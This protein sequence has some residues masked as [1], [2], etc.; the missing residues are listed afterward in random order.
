MVRA[1]ASKRGGG[2]GTFLP[3]TM[4]K[5]DRQVGRN[6]AGGMGD[7]VLDPLHV[8]HP[9]ARIEARL[10]PLDRTDVAAGDPAFDGITSWRRASCR[11]VPPGIRRPK[12][13]LAVRE[14]ATGPAHRRRSSTAPAPE[15]HVP[16]ANPVLAGQRRRHLDVEP[17][18]Q[19]D[20]QRTCAS[21]S[22]RPSRSIASR[23]RSRL[24]SSTSRRASLR[25][26]SPSPEPPA[27]HPNR[28]DNGRTGKFRAGGRTTWRLDV[29]E[30]HRE[31]LRGL[32]PY[33]MRS[34][35]STSTS[36]TLAVAVS[37]VMRRRNR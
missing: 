32:A 18:G 29:R 1:A 25:I 37:P 6:T 36:W 30:A 17:P 5:R 35:S 9:G 15:Q 21:S 10:R 8:G 31:K 4:A 16:T 28:P 34:V 2:G 24:S 3:L 20:G 14:P 11:I 13:H 27:V 23:V 19:D 26:V 12:V 33:R 7:D 22:S